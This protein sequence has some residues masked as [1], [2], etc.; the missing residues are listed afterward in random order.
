MMGRWD[1]GGLEEGVEGLSDKRP[2]RPCHCDPVMTLEETDA[3]NR[4]SPT[5]YSTDTSPLTV[6]MQ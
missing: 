2:D 1:W 3:R 5:P 4:Q 6:E